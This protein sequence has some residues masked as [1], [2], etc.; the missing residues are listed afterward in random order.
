MVSFREWATQNQAL[1]LRFL[2]ASLSH[3]PRRQL[4]SLVHPCQLPLITG[5]K[6]F[7]LYFTVI[8]IFHCDN[9]EGKFC[10]C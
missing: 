8:A 4:P 7:A 2:I 3:H 1:I 5:Q 6:L 9:N 10:E